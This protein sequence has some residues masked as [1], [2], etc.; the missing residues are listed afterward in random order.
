MSNHKTAD[1]DDYWTSWGDTALL[2]E[3]DEPFGDVAKA[4]VSDVLAKCLLAC[5][6]QEGATDELYAARQEAVHRN[7]KREVHESRLDESRSTLIR[8]ELLPVGQGHEQ[9]PGCD[10]IQPVAGPCL[11]SWRLEYADGR[12][13]GG[14]R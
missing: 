2:S 1:A 14:L 6:A 10:V 11:S 9:Q 12:L 7:L 13:L 4:V 3:N 5:T 8:E